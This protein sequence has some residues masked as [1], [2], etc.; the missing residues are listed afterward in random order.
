MEDIQPAAVATDEGY[1][2]PG[3]PPPDLPVFNFSE[4]SIELI[5]PNPWQP[6]KTFGAESLQELADSIKEHGVLQPLVVIHAGDGTYQL[7]V[8]ERR[9]RAAKLAG[10]SK[11]PVII[12]DAMEEQ[13]K[14]ELALIENIQR[15][16]L[17]PIEEAMAYQQLIDQYQMTQDELGKKMGK[18]R[19]TITNALRL[20]HLPLKIQRAVAEGI[21]SEGHARAI[22]G[23]PGMERQLAFME[24]IIR[25]G[26]TVR[27]AEERVREILE[28]PKVIKAPR[29]PSDPEVAA[30]EN[31]LRGKLGTKVKVQKNGDG[32]KVTIEFF[33]QEE[34]SAFLDKVKK[35]EQ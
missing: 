3:P 24:D 12:R 10:L 11:V 22:L 20:L 19:T 33:S 6:R 5:K 7:I 23:L 8:G 1:V 30:L 18:G 9:L 29:A 34:L 21:V 28:R 17:D 13:K 26:L 31:E 16:N 14:L 4:V 2:K 27:Q 32:R 15:H 25:D 35:L